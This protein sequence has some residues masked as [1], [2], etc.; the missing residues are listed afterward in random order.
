M[1]WLL[2]VLGGAL[3]A[4]FRFLVDRAVQRRQSTEFPW[5]TFTA[6]TLG[7]LFL[8]VLTG[9]LMSGEGGTRYEEFVATGL[10]GALTTYSTFSWETVHLAR[11]GQVVR[12][13]G[14][15]AS[16]VLSGLGAVAIGLMVARVVWG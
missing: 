5:G 3:G 16:T 8:G 9:A 7:C 4:P 14:S 13:A 1:N 11:T 10:C 12:A 6:N 15:A 2:V